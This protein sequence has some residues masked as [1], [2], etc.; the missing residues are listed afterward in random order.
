MN[1]GLYEGAWDLTSKPRNPAIVQARGR[2]FSAFDK[3][4]LA[5][6]ENHSLSSPSRRPPSALQFIPRTTRITSTKHQAPHQPLSPRTTTAIVVR[7]ARIAALAVRFC[8]G[9]ARGVLPRDLTILL[10]NFSDPVQRHLRTQAV[11][12]WFSAFSNRLAVSAA[13]S[14]LARY[15][16]FVVRRSAAWRRLVPEP[17]A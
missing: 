16:S 13:S 10:A 14:A 2:G 17:R 11:I 7:V 8:V 6:F 5:R 9:T 15:S 12:F 3:M 4:F 1:L